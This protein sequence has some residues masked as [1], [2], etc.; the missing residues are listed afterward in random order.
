MLRRMESPPAEESNQV[1]DIGAIGDTAKTTKITEQD[2][3]S[4]KDRTEIQQ[5]RQSPKDIRTDIPGDTEPF[6]DIKTE[7]QGDSE[8]S[9]D[10]RTESQEN[11]YENDTFEDEGSEITESI[12]EE[13]QSESESCDSK[14]LGSDNGDICHNIFSSENKKDE[15]G[16]VAEIS[17]S[18]DS[19][20]KEEI[21]LE[22]KSQQ[23]SKAVT[24]YHQYENVEI[25][26]DEDDEKK[27][28]KVDETIT[29]T[30]TQSRTDIGAGQDDTKSSIVVGAGKD[31]HARSDIGEGVDE[32]KSNEEKVRSEESIVDDD[33]NGNF[34]EIP[35]EL[36]MVKQNTVTDHGDSGSDT[37]QIDERLSIK[38]EDNF[39]SF[40]PSL[41][42]VQ[43]IKKDTLDEK[44]TNLDKPE[45]E[46]VV[47]ETDF[48]P[49]KKE[50]EEDLESMKDEKDEDEDKSSATDTSNLA[51]I[52][53]KHVLDTAVSTFNNDTSFSSDEGLENDEGSVSKERLTTEGD[54]SQGKHQNDTDENERDERKEQLELQI[55]IDSL[56]REECLPSG[57]ESGDGQEVEFDENGNRRGEPEV[58]SHPVAMEIAV[59]MVID[60][61]EAEATRVTDQIQEDIKEIS[62]HI[63]LNDTIET[64]QNV[65]RTVENG[66]EH[67]SSENEADIQTSVEP[68]KKNIFLEQQPCEDEEACGSQGM[69]KL[70][71]LPNYPDYPINYGNYKVCRK[72]SPREKECI[73]IDTGEILTCKNKSQ[74]QTGTL[75]GQS[76]LSENVCNRSSTPQ[77]TMN[78]SREIF[79]IENNRSPQRN[80]ENSFRIMKNSYDLRQSPVTSPRD[81]YKANNIARD[82][83]ASHP[84]VPENIGYAHVNLS[85]SNPDEDTGTSSVPATQH[86]LFKHHDD[87]DYE[88]SRRQ[89][90][91]EENLQKLNNESDLRHGM[92]PGG[93]ITHMDYSPSRNLYNTQGEID[94]SDPSVMVRY[95]RNI[96]SQNLYQNLGNASAP[97]VSMDH[98]HSTDPLRMSESESALLSQMYARYGNL[99]SQS[100][101]MT[102]S[103]SD[104]REISTSTDAVSTPPRSGPVPG[105]RTLH[106]QQNTWM[107]MFKT[108]EEKHQLDLQQQNRLHKESL[109]NLQQHMENELFDQQKN[110]RQKLTTHKEALSHPLNRSLSPINSV[111]D[112]HSKSYSRMNDS[113]ISRTAENLPQG[114]DGTLSYQETFQTHN[115][116]LRNRSPSWR[117][118]YKE[119]RGVDASD[120]DEDHSPRETVRRSLDRDF[121]NSPERSR[122]NI[123][124]QGQKENNLT[125]QSYS[126]RERPSR[127]SHQEPPRAG[128]YS[129]PMPILRGKVNNTEQEIEPTVTPPRRDDRNSNNGDRITS[130]SMSEK[131]QSSSLQRLLESHHQERLQ[132]QAQRDVE[133]AGDPT[134]ADD[135]FLS[136]STRVSLREKHAKHMADLREYYEKELRELRGSLLTDMTEQTPYKR[137]SSENQNLV[138]ENR[139]LRE[140]IQDMENGTTVITRQCRELEQINHG[141]E[142]RAKEY[143]ENLNE[144]Q[145]KLNNFRNKMEELQFYYREKDES[146]EQLEFQVKHLNDKIRAAKK[147]NQEL[148]DQ[149][150]R[151]R[152]VL[153]KISDKCEAAE[154]DQQLIKESLSNTE[155]KLYDARTEIVELKRTV[156]KLELENKRLSRE[157]DNLHRRMQTGN[158]I[159]HGSFHD[160]FESPTSDYV[161][162]P[163]RETSTVTV[164]SP[165]GV[166]SPRSEAGSR[167]NT[168][169]DNSMSERER[170][171]GS[172]GDLSVQSSSRSK[173]PLRNSANGYEQ[174]GDSVLE[175]S[176]D[177]IDTSTVSPVMRAEQDLYRLR[178]MMR[179]IGQSPNE[180]PKFK[181]KKKFYGSDIQT[182]TRNGDFSPG[183]SPKIQRK[184]SPSS[185]PKTKSTQSRRSQDSSNGI[186]NNSSAR[187][188]RPPSKLSVNPDEYSS[189]TRFDISTD[190]NKSNGVIP[191]RHP[192]DGEPQRDENKPSNKS[193]QSSKVKKSKKV[194]N[195]SHDSRSEVE[196][197]L[198]RIRSGEYVTRPEWEDLYTSMAK[199]SDNQPVQPMPRE[200]K[201]RDRLCNITDLEHR[202]DDLSA[203]KRTLESTLS[204]IPIHGKGKQEKERVDEKLDQVERELGS[205]RMSL[206][207]YNVLKTSI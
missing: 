32:P 50:D 19:K 56:T 73:I 178:D 40:D 128:V 179:T 156:S 192:G 31:E 34:Q 106:E 136:A 15:T 172:L 68:Q 83:T 202:Y 131:K 14:T 185:S 69:P 159:L 92:Q 26:T 197:T 29:T 183:S 152:G 134:N 173:S 111:H 87:H 170:M 125:R 194:L 60:R 133:L 165:R 129:S 100:R 89:L 193:A 148:T 103:Y 187:G 30:E 162:S 98:S 70:D 137:V 199:P 28:F 189:P 90:R 102:G 74:E 195:G 62:E 153:H 49:E 48:K 78:N 63:S 190:K 36:L 59:S 13:I 21:E 142:I 184:K 120:C 5:D 118:I 127:S 160:S 180:P 146:A 124:G 164:K 80:G 44:D 99:S 93:R 23:S 157:N 2:T 42:N 75:Q 101:N 25:T 58:T 37:N 113:Q 38:S 79:G 151:E 174:L 163:K 130:P 175:S 117:E 12:K 176:I 203:E 204:R 88:T 4:F 149:I 119:I 123:E 1:E 61:K 143:A 107:Q 168:R 67:L 196:D 140:K 76:D 188:Q 201:I 177:Q 138:I 191:R 16:I 6:K 141:L 114:R 17:E 86:V 24:E 122:S 18:H 200:E 82:Q 171:N 96:L 158:S 112:E 166:K 161:P 94:L 35:E 52:I 206:K 20:N 27:E 47:M 11:D 108:L 41:G 135:V 81:Q 126:P 205:I 105:Y 9:E 110:F 91:N 8:P 181:L 39:E 139:L 66:V 7:I 57:A 53:V 155:N 71:P 109:F 33:E 95:Q 46:L 182:Q 55:D 198:N 154:R 10:I 45:T 54:G 3:D 64:E 77:E 85:Q 116:L 167:S 22:D 43:N 104:E 121:S 132:Q 84:N 115:S 147:T 145:A 207:R 186:L 65:S 144:S 51:N 169:R 72:L 97:E 150:Q